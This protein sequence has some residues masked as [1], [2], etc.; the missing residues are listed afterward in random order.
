[1][2]PTRVEW[3][4]SHFGL[5]ICDLKRRGRDESLP[6]VDPLQRLCH[7]VRGD[8]TANQNGGR[9]PTFESPEPKENKMLA[10]P[11]SEATQVF[12]IYPETYRMLKDHLGYKRFSHRRSRGLDGLLL[13]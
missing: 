9:V 11:V 1:M 13:V 2:K 5:E 4:G 8:R 3:F 12:I 7:R 10:D 6:F